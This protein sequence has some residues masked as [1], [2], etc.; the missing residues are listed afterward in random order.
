M[1][2]KNQ[3]YTTT[4]ATTKKQ[5]FHSDISVLSEFGPVRKNSMIPKTELLISEE[6][7]CFRNKFSKFS[8]TTLNNVFGTKF[9]DLFFELEIFCHVTEGLI[10]IITSIEDIKNSY[11]NTLLLIIVS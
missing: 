10:N 8:K 2:D 6:I 9:N 3:G 5:G 11:M 4:E 7:N 1:E